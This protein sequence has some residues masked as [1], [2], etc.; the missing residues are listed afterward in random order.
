MTA[1]S[2]AL[3]V[4]TAAM[5]YALPGLADPYRL[6]IKDHRFDPTE[7]TLPAGQKIKLVVENQDATPEEFESHDLDREKVIPGHSKGI[8]LVGPLK[9][10]RYK[11]V[12]EFN[13]DTAQ[14]VLVVK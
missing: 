13:E 14:G 12:G 7:L 11:F 9:P 1:R 4:A 5:I 8:V 10:G 6:V 2:F 3:A